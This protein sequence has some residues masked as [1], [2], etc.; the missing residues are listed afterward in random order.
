MIKRLSFVILLALV[1]GCSTYT[2]RNVALRGHLIN[3]QYDLALDVVT[4]AEDPEDELLNLLERA[5]VLHYADNYTES[6]IF[7]EQAE[8][9]AADLYTKSIGQNIVALATNDET[10]DYTSPLF[11]MSMI[12]YYRAMNYH[13]LGLSDDAAVE[14]RKALEFLRDN[15]IESYHFL[16]WFT[17]ALLANV[18]DLND[19]HIAWKNAI[20]G[21]IP[22]IE[23]DLNNSAKLLGFADDFEADGNS[24]KVILFLE[25]GF[26]PHK[27]SV[28]MDVPIYKDDNPQQVALL[29]GNRV[30]HGWKKGRKLSYWLTVAL[31][32]QVVTKPQI[33]ALKVYGKY[34]T[35]VENIAIKSAKEYENGLTKTAVRAAGRALV[36]AKMHS[37]AQESGEV[38]A[39]LVNVFNIATERAD[40]R[41]WLTLP[42]SISMLR[43]DLESGTHSLEVKLLNDNSTVIGT[44]NI[45]VDVKAGQYCFV[46]RRVF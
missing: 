43:L 11:E 22:G 29:V 45:E 30:V 35:V 19:A 20:D 32:D 37:K 41:S 38:A 10:V 44:E 42:H 17:G 18:G 25:S 23:N 46:S 7:F 13:Y 24:G 16:N 3:Q 33:A 9:L 31:P 26:A 36:K 4:E 5:T 6:N 1:T 2:E 14:A 21:N 12:P 8:Q 40:T 39:F 27:V 34:S 15:E 28:E